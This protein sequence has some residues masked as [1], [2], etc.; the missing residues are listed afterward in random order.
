ME[1]VIKSFSF[2]SENIKLV[3]NIKKEV[4]KNALKM[5]ID[6]NV[7]SN[8]T[9]LKRLESQNGSSRN[10][11]LS[12]KNNTIFWM[13]SNNYKGLRWE[14]YDKATGFS[15]YVSVKEMKEHYIEQRE[16]ITQIAEYFYDCIKRFM[17]IKLLYE[18][19]LDDIISEEE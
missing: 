7:I 11:S 3:L 12:Y 10:I 13:S 1:N 17:E 4:Y 18:T 9:D 19:P 2:E 8:N 16:Y 15:L 6:G 5:F 14:D